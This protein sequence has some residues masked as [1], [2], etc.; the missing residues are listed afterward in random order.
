MDVAGQVYIFGKGK[1]GQFTGKPKRDAFRGW[2]R[3]VDMWNKRMHP[4]EAEKKEKASEA[5]Q[6]EQAKGRINTFV[7]M[8]GGK[9][10]GE[11]A[12]GSTIGAKALT[13]S[14]VK[15]STKTPSKGKPRQ[16][17]KLEARLAT[18]RELAAQT[19][20]PECARHLWWAAL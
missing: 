10:K 9:G 7:D 12:V 2:T 15:Q 3:I 11:A 16:R 5:E 8:K 1:A 20:H 4:E 19:R 13:A 14:K 17:V 18:T 6:Q